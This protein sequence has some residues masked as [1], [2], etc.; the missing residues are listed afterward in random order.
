[1]IY[2]PKT[3]YVAE[4]NATT[5]LQVYISTPKNGFPV[6]RPLHPLH[7]PHPPHQSKKKS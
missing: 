2:E 7:P 5:P 3:Q 1:M 4:F 6:L